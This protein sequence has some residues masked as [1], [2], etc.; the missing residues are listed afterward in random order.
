MQH[1]LAL[2]NQVFEIEQRLT[3]QEQFVNF[4]RNFKRINAIFEAEGF[5]CINPIGEK[6]LESRTDCEASIVGS[7]LAGLK[8]SKVIKPIVYKVENGSNTLVQKGIVIAS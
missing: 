4:E 5:L 1:L 6:Y 3:D 2:I 8:I 7:S